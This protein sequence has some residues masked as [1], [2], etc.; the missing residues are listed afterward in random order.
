MDGM[1]RLSFL[2]EILDWDYIVLGF[3]ED[4]YGK[5]CIDWDAEDEPELVKQVI[6]RM[7]DKVSKNRCDR[8]QVYEIKKIEDI[9]ICHDDEKEEK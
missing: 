5:I 6:S 4:K 8:V 9:R 1:E 7:T 3:K 2:M